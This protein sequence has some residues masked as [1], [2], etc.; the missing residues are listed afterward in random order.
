[1]NL[2]FSILEK[3]QGSGLNT[4]RQV[5]TNE[6]ACQTDQDFVIEMQSLMARELE[7]HLGSIE[8]HGPEYDELKGNFD[9]LMD[10]Y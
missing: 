9:T 8:T 10:Q 6:I 7:N 1:M 2:K 3:N 5:K 4:M